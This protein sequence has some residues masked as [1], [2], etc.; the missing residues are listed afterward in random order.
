MDTK[1]NSNEVIEV[2]DMSLET[3]LSLPGNCVYVFENE[4]KKHIQIYSSKNMVS[5]LL[6]T[7]KE[8]QLSGEYSQLRNEM[9]EVKIKILETNLEPNQLR[10]RQSYWIDLYRDKGY[11]LYKEISPIKYTIDV[12]FGYQYGRIHFFV[13][14]KNTRKDTKLI[15]VFPNKT[16]M[17]K[18]MRKHYPGKKVSNIVI[19][20]SVQ[21]YHNSIKDS[22]R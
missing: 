8:I 11:K 13:Y 2:V 19:H 5:H 9:K 15:G 10:I 20:E 18:W 21:V 16:S 6:E 3:L 12:E 1:Q 22:G 14:L 4:N 17:E 7:C